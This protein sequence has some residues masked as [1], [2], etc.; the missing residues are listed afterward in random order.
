M[1]VA[2]IQELANMYCAAVAASDHGQPSGHLYA[3]VAMPRGATL[4]EHELAVGALRRA[5][6]VRV[7]HHLVTWTGPEE[8][9]QRLRAAMED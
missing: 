9:R 4:D 6:L 3:M 8:L 7:E 1:T 2:G 5:G